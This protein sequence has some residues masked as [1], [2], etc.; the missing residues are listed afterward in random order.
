MEYR[1]KI[2]QDTDTQ[3]SKRPIYW[4]SVETYSVKANKWFSVHTE[5]TLLTITRY[6]IK[7]G[8]D[9]NTIPLVVIRFYEN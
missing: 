8:L 9:L 7:H 6:M 4:Y 3:V 1:L 2:I 5:T